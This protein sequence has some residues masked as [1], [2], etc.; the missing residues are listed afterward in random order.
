MSGGK[1]QFSV[2]KSAVEAIWEGIR[3]T[4]IAV[5]KELGL[6]P[7]LPEQ[8]H[9]VHSQE[10]LSRYSDLDAKG[11]ERA[12]ARGLGVVL[13]MGIGDKLNDGH[14]HDVCALDY[15]D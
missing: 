10:L 14:R 12:I 1:R 8:I 2:L 11:R 4:E 15:D 7:F 5:S 6:V 9:S 3:V 13:L